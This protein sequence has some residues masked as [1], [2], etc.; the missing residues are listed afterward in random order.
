MRGQLVLI[1]GL[2]RTG[3]STQVSILASRLKD[4]KIFKFPDRTTP[5]G[6]IINE[7]LTNE[8]YDLSDEALHLLFLANRW[9]LASE[10][11]SLLNSEEWVVMDR[12]VYSGLAYLLSKDNLNDIDWLL[13]P[14]RGLPR[15]DA[16][17][18]LSVPPE[19]LATRKDYGDERYE[20]VHFQSKV[21]RNFERVLPSDIT[22]QLDVTGLS[23]SEVSDLIWNHIREKGIDQLTNNNI[24]L[25]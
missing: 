9:E 14:D 12:Y 11:I 5:I 24:T 22:F 13:G 16:I 8:H 10:I 20:K 2:D 7:Y 15:P 6:S 21:K 23:I 18:Y 19:E 1:E 25:I 4:A 17:I 3:K